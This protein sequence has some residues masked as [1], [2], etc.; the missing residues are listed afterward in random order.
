[1]IFDGHDWFSVSTHG[2][3]VYTGG[4]L[5][6]FTNVTV[7]PSYDFLIYGADADAWVGESSGSAPA[8]DDDYSPRLDRRR[9]VYAL[10]CEM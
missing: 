3:A 10:L 9:R 2:A 1:M 6:D 8:V 7:E 4:Y 5:E